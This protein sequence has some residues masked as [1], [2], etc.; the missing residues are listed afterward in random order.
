MSDSIQRSEDDLA[1]RQLTAAY[2]DAV[3]R[4]DVAG[5]AATYAED[6]VLSAF[7]A[8]D[9]VGRENIEATFSQMYS[10]YR[11]IFQ[12]THSGTIEIDGDEAWCRWWV[13]EQSQNQ[14]GKGA[15]FLG[16]YQDHVIRTGS[17]WRF[18]RRLLQ[19]VYL[20][21]RSLEGKIFDTPSIE[22]RPAI[23]GKE[24]APH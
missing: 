19:G 1:I 15:E 11:W 2:S 16:V 18:A 10:D 23:L 4:K 22:P 6:A 12:M 20:G 17:G 14:E 8:P 7:G 3:N 13:S 9:V 24:Q 21:R 5:M